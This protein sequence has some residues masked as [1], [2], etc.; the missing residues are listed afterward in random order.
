M[1]LIIP[2]CLLDDYRYTSTDFE[3]D[4]SLLDRTYFFNIPHDGGKSGM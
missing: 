4:D 1:Q 3:E 2:I